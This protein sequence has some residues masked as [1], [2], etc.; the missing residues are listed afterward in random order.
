[1]GAGRGGRGSSA[2]ST[3]KPSDAAVL[4]EYGATLAGQSPMFPLDPYR[5]SH[6]ALIRQ[7]GRPF[8][9]GRRSGRCL[10]RELK[11]LATQ[12]TAIAKKV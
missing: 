5:P 9:C 2:A 8:R 4:R 10:A 11:A 12:S 7:L 3:H 6:A 1:M